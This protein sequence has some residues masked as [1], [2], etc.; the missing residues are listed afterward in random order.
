MTNWD[1][2]RKEWETSRITLIELADKHGVKEGT[3]KSRKSREGWK[4]VAT[5][6][7]ASEKKKMQPSKKDA[8]SNA[9]RK[10]SGNPNPSNKFPERNNNPSFKHGFYSKCIPAEAK[11]IFDA[12]DSMST[13]DMLWDQIKIMYTNIIRAQEIMFVESKDELIKE[14]KREKNQGGKNP[15]HEIEYELQF[16]WERQAQALSSQARAMSELRTLINQ[17]IKAADE[18]DERRLKLQQMQSS[19]DKVKA[20]IDKLTSDEQNGPIEIKIVGKKRE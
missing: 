16:A 11:A 8:T 9:T 12:I 3:L 13:A 19:I 10:R 7:D 1:D 18:A 15:S 20:E 14:L 17:F 2:I 6:K 4:K 5:K